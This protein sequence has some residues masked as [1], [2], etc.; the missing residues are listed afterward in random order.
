M[1]NSK[2][3]LTAALAM[4]GA[5]HPDQG[6]PLFIGG[7][8]DPITAF[9]SRHGVGGG[10]SRGKQPSGMTKAQRAKKRK[11]ERLER[12]RRAEAAKHRRQTT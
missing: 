11:A 8:P 1:F 2:R 6:R 7:E 5:M 10:W 12:Q 4:A 9:Y 3:D